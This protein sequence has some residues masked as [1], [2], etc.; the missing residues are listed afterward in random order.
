[1][2]Y[3]L[4]L[5]CEL[6]IDTVMVQYPIGIQTFSEIRRQ[7]LQYIDKTK[8]IY[9]LAHG[10]K[11]NF[12]SRPRRFGKSLLVTTLQAYFEGKKELFKGLAIDKLETEWVEYPV[13]HLDLSSGKYYEYRRLLSTLDNILMPYEKEYGITPKDSTAFGDR[14]TNIIRAAVSKTGKQAVIL[15][16]EY[17]SPMLDSMSDED[18]QKKIRNTLRDFFSPLKANEGNLRFVFLTG[19][20]KFSQLSIFSELNNINN[21]SMKDEFAAICGF[22]KQ[23]VLENFHD[24][25][26]KMAD[27]NDMTFDE[28]VEKIKQRYDGYRF[29]PH[30]ENIYNPYSLLNALNDKSFESYWFESGTPTFLL[31]LMQNKNMLVPD[32]EDIIATR[33]QFDAP[34]ERAS[35]PVP[36][37]YQSGYITIKHYDYGVYTL[38]FPNEEVRQ[39][40]NTFTLNY[41][42]PDYGRQR[43][44]FGFRFGQALRAGDVDTAMK[45]LKVFLAGFP[46]DV[47]HNREDYFQ[48]ILYTVFVT[49]NFTIRSEV[50]TATGRIDLLVQTK[51]YIYVM[52]LKLDKSVDEAL[53]QIDSKD[54]ALPYK[55]DGRKV[56]K[57]GVNF[58]SKERNVTDWKVVE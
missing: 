2:E 4:N 18:L 54:Y 17:D 14:L 42:A 50:K 34:T 32:L 12:L 56:F 15:I 16:D 38:A 7:G 21:L 33:D 39:G 30:G 46:Y 47:H 43:T 13:I 52:E 22:T 41:I 25:I 9:M 36:V 27:A 37:L 3:F 1:M 19:I 29:S 6:Y 8:F 58:S 53:A 44:A 51:D 10:T 11:N 28:A 55:N 5:P 24:G 57:I 23:E 45:A 49:I 35:D 20:S 31:E 26:E 40:F 48:A